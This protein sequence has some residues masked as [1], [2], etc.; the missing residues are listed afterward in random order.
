MK[1]NSSLTLDSEFLSYCEIN[2]IKDI[3]ALARKIFQRGFTIEK[4]G[5]IP[6]SGN[7]I[8][9]EVVEKE[10][11]VEVIKEVPVERIVEVIKE[12]SNNEEIEKLMKENE[13]LSKYNMCV[14]Q[15]HSSMDT[16]YPTPLLLNLPV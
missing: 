14:V 8:K 13:N 10:T 3:E 15:Y 5:E 11:I 6:T 1:K 9:K 4:Y 7:S 2:E 12:V 16:S